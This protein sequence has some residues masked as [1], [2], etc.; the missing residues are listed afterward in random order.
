MTTGANSY[1]AATQVASLTKRYTTAGVYDAASNPTVTE[2]ESWIDDV[3]ATMNAVLA[4]AGFSIP[5]TQTDA[6]AAIA[7]FVVGVVAD[8]CHAQNN[9]GRFFTQKAL[10]SGV[11]PLAAIRRELKAWVE[12][13]AAGLAALGAARTLEDQR[14]NS[15]VAGYITMD[16]AEHS[17]GTA[18]VEE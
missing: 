13:N 18:V 16:I 6:K 17:D 5:V 3:S 9:A 11:N 8:L 4:G 1:G 10:E 2:V 7:A 12:E 15:L 14:S